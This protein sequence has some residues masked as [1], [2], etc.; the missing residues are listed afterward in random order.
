[1]KDIGKPC[2]GKLHARFDEGGLVKAARVLLVRHRHTKGTE[3]D[4]PGL[5]QQEPVLYSTLFFRMIMKKRKL[6]L[7]EELP[8]VK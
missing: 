8:L 3:T 7:N 1:M 5:K 2:A 4:R 6:P